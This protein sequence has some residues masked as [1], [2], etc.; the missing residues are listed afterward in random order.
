MSN[1]KGISVTNDIVP[2]H[3]RQE[4]NS[5][6]ADDLIDAYNLGKIE[7]TKTHIKDINKKFTQNLRLATIIAEEFLESANKQNIPLKEI[8]LKVHAI[9]TFE[10]LFIVENNAAFLNSEFINAYELTWKF[11]DKY[12]SDN[13][14]VSF[15]F[16]A[17]G[18][19][20]ERDNIVADKF[21]LKYEKR[22]EAS[23]RSA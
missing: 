23:T 19:D 1:V 21:F 2:V 18:K 5:Y 7:G 11:E 4:G 3:W 15:S 10:A 16:V 6:T 8:Y 22:K 12:N 9:N 13:F 17:D 14:Y 20:L